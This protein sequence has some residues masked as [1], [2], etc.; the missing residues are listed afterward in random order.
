MF[1]VR[2]GRN[3]SVSPCNP[4]FTN[5]IHF[6]LV[7][8]TQ[9]YPHPQ[10]KV[11]ALLLLQRFFPSYILHSLFL[12]LYTYT[13]CSFY[14]IFY[15]F[16]YS[17]CLLLSH[18]M[19]YTFFFRFA[20]GTRKNSAVFPR[21]G[22]HFIHM[23]II[24]LSLLSLKYAV[25]LIIFSPN[26]HYGFFFSAFICSGLHIIRLRASMQLSWGELNYILISFK[27]LRNVTWGDPVLSFKFGCGDP[28]G[29]IQYAQ[30]L[31]VFTEGTL[32]LCF[33]RFVVPPLSS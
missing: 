27:S 22:R 7:A 28:F 17:E 24:I 18:Q 1:Y 13:G 3:Y 2:E 16:L 4:V 8:Y 20:S 9:K 30:R 15:I 6:C 11:F 33:D 12:F 14:C 25:K 5:H 21:A 19:L 31:G 29:D 32:K 26:L 23:K 10:H